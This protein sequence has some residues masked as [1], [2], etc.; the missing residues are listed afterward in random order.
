MRGAVMAR[1]AVADRVTNTRLNNIL[2]NGNFELKPSYV[3]DT[4]TAGKW[5]DGT[6]AG[7]GAKLAYGWGTPATGSGVGANA[8][9]AFDTSQFRS[10]TASMR[11]SNLNASGA[12][13]IASYA[14]N[15]IASTAFQ[16]FRLIPNT[17]YT[18]R[19]YVRTNNVATN[20]AFIDVREYSAAIAT[21]ATNSSNKLSGTDTSWRQ[22]TATFTTNASTVF[23]AVFL[24]NNVAGN[25]SDAWFDDITLVPATTGRVA[26][27]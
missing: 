26:V 10:G 12:V 1:I 25:T 4:N 5:I 8:A 13:T 7:S 14:L 24:R 17:S 15:P 16:L 19:G 20:S 23:G 27:S 9:A 21:L 11:L 6:A 18:M 2:Y 3:A 22:V